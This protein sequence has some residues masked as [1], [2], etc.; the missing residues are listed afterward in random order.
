MAGRPSRRM[1]LGA[2]LALWLFAALLPAL[3]T[4]AT[5]SPNDSKDHAAVLL[6]LLGSDVAAYLGLCPGPLIAYLLPL[7]VLA[8]IIIWLLVLGIVDSRDE[9][10]LRSIAQTIALLI[11]CWGILQMVGLLMTATVEYLYGHGVGGH[12]FAWALDLMLS[13]L[14]SG[15][16]VIG[17]MAAIRYRIRSHALATF[18]A[19]LCASVIGVLGIVARMHNSL[20]APGGIDQALLSGDRGR[21]WAAAFLA[22]I[23]CLAPVL[24]AVLIAKSRREATIGKRRPGLAV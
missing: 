21:W 2:A 5:Q 10:S 8:P 20:W 9:A 12:A 14:V 18:A 15:L 7:L 16:P 23:G 17:L 1:T 11:A 22:T 24:A 13:M 6:H 19:L 3:A 4:A